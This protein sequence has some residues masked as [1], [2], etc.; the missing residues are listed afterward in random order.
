MIRIWKEEVAAYFKKS[1]SIFMEALR[2]NTKMKEVI[3]CSFQVQSRSECVLTTS[4]SSNS[5]RMY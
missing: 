3:G 4:S 1:N 2:K 5:Y